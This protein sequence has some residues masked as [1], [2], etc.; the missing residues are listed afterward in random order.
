MGD[1]VY[2]LESYTQ[3]KSFDFLLQLHFAQKTMSKKTKTFIVFFVVSTMIVSLW[4]NKKHIKIF[5][6]FL[7][8]SNYQSKEIESNSLN[9]KNSTFSDPNFLCKREER[10]LNKKSFISKLSNSTER[11][12]RRDQMSKLKNEPLDLVVQDIKGKTWDLYC[13]RGQKHLIINLWATWCSPCVEELLSLSHFA[14]K[15]KENT[16][17]IALSIESPETVFKFIK[18]AFP[19]LKK[20]LKIA[21]L[22]EKKLRTYFPED[23]LPV[24]Y[25]FNKEGR[26][27][28]KIGGARNWNKREMIEIFLE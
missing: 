20:S 26:L 16:V 12:T 1:S 7:N 6:Y 11:L 9:T 28:K 15:T 4:V 2:V 27:S 8:I 13:Y 17:V 14:E 25:I 19:D 10:S 23:P 22:P 24:T 18:K 21:S 5:N 3:K